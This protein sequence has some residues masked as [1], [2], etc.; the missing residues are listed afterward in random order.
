[1]IY[2]HHI[3]FGVIASIIGLLSYPLYFRDILKGLSK[4]H[5]FSWF[6]WFL[7]TGITFLIQLA[8]GGGAGSIVTGVESLCCFA[9]AV[10]AYTKGEREITRSDWVCFAL[11]LVAIVLWQ[12]ADAPTFAVVMVIVADTLALIPTLRKSYIKP[13][14]ETASQ[15][16]LSSLHWVIAII[17]LESLAPANW[18][19]PAW[20]AT[21]DMVLVAVLL[22]RRKQLR[23]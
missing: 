20:M 15:Y 22:V 7:L 10:L 18:L 21:F 13:H 16:A 14:Q 9:L 17:A 6:I 23:V 4:P 1:M 12:L 5:V 3:V 19:V 11:A 8:E 2:D